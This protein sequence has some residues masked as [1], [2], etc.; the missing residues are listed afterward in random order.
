MTNKQVA[1]EILKL[2]KAIL[3]AETF[4]CPTCGTKVLKQTGYCVK[5][6]K[7]VQPKKSSVLSAKTFKCPECGTKVLEQTGYCVKCK[8]KVK[9][10][11]I[12]AKT[13]RRF[14]AADPL[15]QAMNAYADAHEEPDYGPRDLNWK[16]PYVNA[17]QLADIV[18]K[19]IPGG[20]NKFDS[21]KVG[22][23]AI[24]NGTYK[25]ALAREHSVAIYIKGLKNAASVADLVQD[26]KRVKADEISLEKGGSN[27]WVE[28]AHKMSDLM[29]MEDSDING[30]E[31]R[32][33]WD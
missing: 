26:F 8:K 22:K 23:T 24:T 21:E 16:G 3:S 31:L 18:K 6:K 27:L 19:A 30:A 9:K 25:Y 33:W 5:C 29:K 13:T 12:R 32:L 2:A 10:S 7:K 17:R 15:Q 28:W 1:M 14:L 4:K 20:Y 11:A